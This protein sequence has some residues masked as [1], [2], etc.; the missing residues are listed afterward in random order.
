MGPEKTKNMLNLRVQSK[1][2]SNDIDGVVILGLQPTIIAFSDSFIDLHRCIYE[3]IC[4]YVVIEPFREI[5]GGFS[6]Q[7]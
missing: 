5:E 1:S 3:I 2:S 7:A 4:I 6:C